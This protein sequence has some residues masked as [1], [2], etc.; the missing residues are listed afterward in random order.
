MNEAS[1]FDG[2]P[3]RPSGLISSYAVSAG[4]FLGTFLAERDILLF[5]TRLRPASLQIE[6]DWFSLGRLHR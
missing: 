4:Y 6:S 1:H 3:I 2:L 5:N